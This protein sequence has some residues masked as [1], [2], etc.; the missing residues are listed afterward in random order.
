MYIENIMT[1]VILLKWLWWFSYGSML[2]L[3]VHC[4]KLS[5]RGKVMVIEIK[6]SEF[7]VRN[8]VNAQNLTITIKG[9]VNFIAVH[10]QCAFKAN[11]VQQTAYSVSLQHCAQYS[12][13]YSVCVALVQH[14]H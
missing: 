12:I 8:L 14:K 5:G 1:S 2:A 10:M 3:T 7:W 6:V 11:S 9:A 4:V 13:K